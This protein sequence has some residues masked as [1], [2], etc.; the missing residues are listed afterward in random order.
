MIL[1]AFASAFTALVPLYQ[2]DR[3]DRHDSRHHKSKWLQMV[4][5]PSQNKN[6]AEPYGDGRHNDDEEGS[7]HDNLA[8]YAE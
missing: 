4:A 8:R 5:E 7:V 6:V 2:D 3:R 1:S